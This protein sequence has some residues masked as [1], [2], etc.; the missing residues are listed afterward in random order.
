M[1]LAITLYVVPLWGLYKRHNTMRDVFVD[2]AAAAGLCCRTNVS[3]P[4]TSL[5][6]ADLLLPS[7]TDVPTAVDVSVVHPLHPSRSA[8]AAVT[9][10]AA[11]EARAEEKLR[12][13][14]K[15]CTEG[16]GNSG[17]W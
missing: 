1:R 12:K 15:Q 10:G 11:A 14:G 3:L 9:A 8:Q 2:L 7:F 4:G 13:C 16:R 17:Q 6:P 5:I